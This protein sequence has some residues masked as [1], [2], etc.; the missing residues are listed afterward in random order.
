MVNLDIDVPDDVAAYL[1][2]L[3]DVSA[4]VIALI[5]PLI[6]NPQSHRDRPDPALLPNPQSHRNAPSPGE[7]DT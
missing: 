2:S 4:T 6:P 7:P 1:Q 5:Q 3:G